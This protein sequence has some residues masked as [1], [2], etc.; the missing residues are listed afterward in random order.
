MENF[1]NIAR[2]TA[3]L[4][5]ARWNDVANNYFALNYC[6][7]SNP[8]LNYLILSHYLTYIVDRQMPFQRIWD[9]GGYV[10]S[11]LVEKYE[12]TN[13]DIDS[14]LGLSGEYSQIEGDHLYFCAPNTTNA[15]LLYAEK[16]N[17]KI[18][19]RSRFVT[20]DYRSIYNTLYI[21]DKI[22]HRSIIDYIKNIVSLN[23]GEQDIIKRITFGLFLLTY[24]GIINKKRT[25]D[26]KDYISDANEY[27]SKQSTKIRSVLCDKD[28]FNKEYY[29]YLHKQIY[30]SKRIWCSI[31]DYIKDERYSS[32]FIKEIFDKEIPTTNLLKQLVLPGDVW[33]NNDKFQQCLF[34]N[35]KSRIPLNVHLDNIFKDQ[36]TDKALD[37]CYAEQ[38]DITFSLA[39]RMCEQGNCELC[40]YSLVHSNKNPT[41]CIS[42]LCINNTNKLCPIILFATGYKMNCVGSQICVLHIIS[43]QHPSD[44]GITMIKANMEEGENP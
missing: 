26:T 38:F 20:T 32:R 37:N 23:K 19:F 22:S 7:P 36:K 34:G 44:I 24:D 17:N 8:S 11:S 25:E 1:I 21:L 28:L 6:S 33:N 3:F 40:P 16:K 12:Q 27:A 42:Q 29:Q 10:F 35:K 30:Y 5:N 4:D 13:C 41:N 39:P 2:I 9:I 15:K 31:R 43:K 18:I 14:L